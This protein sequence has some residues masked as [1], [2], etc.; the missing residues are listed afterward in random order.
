MTN[1]EK[2]QM[3]T[4]GKRELFGYSKIKQ[5]GLFIRHNTSKFELNL[6]E[7][8]EKLR[9]IKILGH[10]KVVVYLDENNEIKIYTGTRGFFPNEMKPYMGNS[11]IQNL[12]K[13]VLDGTKNSIEFHK[14]N[15]AF[16]TTGLKFSSKYT[17][18]DFEVPNE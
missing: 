6:Q 16:K 8:I 14:R 2:D 1:F 7:P 11:K 3:Y 17:Y 13:I 4:N 18:F 12:R 10:T 5:K 15:E 9:K